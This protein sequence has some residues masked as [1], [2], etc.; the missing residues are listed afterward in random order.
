MTTQ[1]FLDLAVKAQE[2]YEQETL[3]LQSDFL[4]A[5][6]AY[7]RRLEER[8]QVIRNRAAQSQLVAIAYAREHQSL[9]EEIESLDDLKSNSYA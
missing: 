5:L 3:R 8:A 1:Q 6:E 9:M 7:K 2:D 4:S